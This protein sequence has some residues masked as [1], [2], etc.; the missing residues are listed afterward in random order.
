MKLLPFLLTVLSATVCLS[1]ADIRIAVIPKDTNHAFWKSVEKGAR[2]AATELKVEI[3]WKGPIKGD[4]RA[5]QIAI[6]QQ[7][8][9]SGVSGI[10]LAPLDDIALRS[11]VASAGQFKIPVVIYD[12]PLQGEV[13]KDFISLVATDN[14]LGGRLAGEE[15]A[16]LLGGQGKVVLLRFAESSASTN[17]REA[18][19]LEVMASHPGIEIIS[20]NRYAG[21]TASTAQDTAMN[22]LDKLRETD[23]IFCPNE[24]STVGMLLALRQ[25]GL[26]GKKKFVGFDASAPILAGIE[27]GQIDAV[28]AQNPTRMGYL[29]VKTMVEHLQGK[30]V[31]PRI[32]TGCALVTAANMGSPEIRAIL[33]N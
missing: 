22:M 19:F 1:G 9:A 29:A 25:A 18:G 28:V 16:R 23:G 4:D 2:Q 14:R 10:A 24:S 6:V 32:D 13:G 15:L 11:P 33:G 7:F 3:I 17:Q 21:V 26:A 31:E 12:S 8:V 5:Q 30:P 27:R 20:G